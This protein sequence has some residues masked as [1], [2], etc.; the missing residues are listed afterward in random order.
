[1]LNNV[2]RL[3]EII[4]IKINGLNNYNLSVFYFLL[5]V[6]FFLDKRCSAIFYAR[7]RALRESNMIALL[8]S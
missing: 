3:R 7:T 5:K 1:M 4:S 8:Q 2:V 6:W